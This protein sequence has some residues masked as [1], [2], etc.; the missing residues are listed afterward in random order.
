M[1][2]ERKL[3]KKG[4]G[5][6]SNR[7]GRFETQ[8]S[9]REFDGWEQGG[10]DEADYE[11]DAG[12]PGET[13]LTRDATRSI[14][15]SNRSPDLPFDASINP[16]RGCEHGC[17]YCYARPSHA[18][19]GHSPGLDF[20]REL[21]Y[22][23]EAGA[24]LRAE[25]ARP[26]YVPKTIALGT[27]TDPYQPIERKLRIMRDILEVLCAHRHPVAITTKGSLIERDIDLLSDMAAD[28][29]AVAA[30][31][32][33]TLDGELA[34]KLEPRASAP[35]R[36][37]Q[38]IERLAAAGIPVHVSVAPVIPAVNDAEIEKL[39]KAAV[40]AGAGSAGWIMVR[41]PGEVE[42]LFEEWLAEHLPDRA[43]KVMNK[44]RDAHGGRGND[45]R[46]HH[47]FHAEGPYAEA[48]RARFDI[49]CRRLG[50]GARVRRLS[51]AKFVPPSK[52][53]EQLSL[54]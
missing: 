52:D 42:Q 30:V 26:G 37:L 45:P 32:F 23:P 13:R 44:I 8:Q 22:K 49:A 54:L 12:S 2:D 39:L 48:V 36:R 53:P 6:L 1:D 18:Y 11:A 3:A 20:E 9:E 25:L 31:S 7:A 40:D 29:C 24:L 38:T 41:L 51:S 50:L 28:D 19:L 33:T 35:H 43:A 34:R 15:V 14:I 21:H 16:Y 17:V 47:R 4:R 27:N 5:A 10:A 46:F